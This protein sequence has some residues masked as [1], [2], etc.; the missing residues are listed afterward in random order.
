MILTPSYRTNA[1][2]VRFRKQ[3]RDA[4][5]QV[6]DL[7]VHAS[8]LRVLDKGHRFAEVDAAKRAPAHVS[9]ASRGS[10]VYQ[11]L[12]RHGEIETCAV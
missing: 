5:A 11:M 4:R 2:L 7:V 8:S 1:S 10:R 3:R 12:S 9:A 6:G